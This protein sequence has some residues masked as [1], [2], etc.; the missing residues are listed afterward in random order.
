M[1]DQVADVSCK[2]MYISVDMCVLMTVMLRSSLDG[3]MQPVDD[4]A[5]VI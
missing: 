3:C 5:S 4:H 1:E 2:C